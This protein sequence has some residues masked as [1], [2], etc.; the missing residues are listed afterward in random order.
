MINI[1]TDNY[2]VEGEIR[3]CYENPLDASKCIKILKPN[4]DEAYAY[5]EI[6]YFLKL[7]RRKNKYKYPFYSTFHGEVET[8][9]GKGQVFDLIRDE[10]TGQ[11]SKTLEFYLHNNTPYNDDAL[12]HE[13]LMLKDQMINFKVFT[14]DL[15]ARNLCC[16]IKKNNSIEL[17]IVDG[18]GHRDFFPL[19]DWMLYFSKKKVMRAFKRWHFLNIKQQ[20]EFLYNS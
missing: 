5:K 14:I 13:L 16:R 8:N 11:I 19:A 1:Y 2:I 3:V 12:N 7:N 18:I 10:T 9:K 15:R 17:V 6:N 4:I 20:R